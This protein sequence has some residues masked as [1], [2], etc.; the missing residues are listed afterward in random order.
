MAFIHTLLFS[1]AVFKV[2]C[3]DHTYTTLKLP[4]DARVEQLLALTTEKLGLG[5]DLLLCE[6]KSTGGNQLKSTK[7]S[8]SQCF[9][10][11]SPN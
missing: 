10:A 9:Y 6:V 8:H 11:L 2:Y 7:H 5:D 3:A 1:T 4:M